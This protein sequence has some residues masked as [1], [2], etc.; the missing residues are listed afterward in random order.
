MITKKQ[1]GSN[2]SITWLVKAGKAFL[3]KFQFGIR[4]KGKFQVV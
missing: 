1:F 2:G 3:T 4:K